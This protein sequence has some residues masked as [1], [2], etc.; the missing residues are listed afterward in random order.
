MSEECAPQQEFVSPEKKI[1]E[2]EHV[3]QNIHSQEK[4]KPTE[5]ESDYEEFELEIEYEEKDSYKAEPLSTNVPIALSFTA[6]AFISRSLWN[7]NVLAMF[8]YK[9]SG[10]DPRAIGYC[11]SLM[12]LLQLLSSFVGGYFADKYR[13]DIVIRYSAVIGFLSAVLIISSVALRNLSFVVVAFATVGTYWGL[14]TTSLSALFADSLTD[15]Q[16][17]KY[18]TWRYT[19]QKLGNLAAPILAIAMFAATGNHWSENNCAGVIYFSQ[20]LGL[21]STL[22]PC[23]MSDD[24]TPLSD[25][26]SIKSGDE[27][28]HQNESSESNGEA[29]EIKAPDS[30]KKNA[31]KD[32]STVT[33]SVQSIATIEPQNEKYDIIIPICICAADILQ[34]FANGMSVQFFPV[35]FAKH[36][37]MRPIYVQIVYFFSQAGQAYGSI[38]GFRL[39]KKLGRCPVTV[40]LRCV[41]CL[42]LGLMILSHKVKLGTTVVCTFYVFRMISTN[43]S[44]PLTGSILMD[45]VPKHHRG[46]W[47][48]L[49]SLVKASWSGSAFIGGFLIHRY[50][51]YTVINFTIIMQVIATIPICFLFKRVLD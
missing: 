50:D 16:R 11:T 51:I 32:A 40:F 37:F 10:H 1:S 15:E 9:V 6:L 22:I 47:G 21:V 49:D 44:V 3:Q 27:E 48:S 45:Y 7:Q 17:P 38:V 31:E 25:A 34:G 26:P 19:V 13:R 20:A 8:I 30:P 39:G 42:A 2:Q 33:D 14:T 23:F 18:I 12:G 29:V 35:F 4:E 36:L 28:A 46:K 5:R 43:S 41:G 24:K